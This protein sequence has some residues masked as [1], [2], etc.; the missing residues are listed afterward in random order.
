MS[1]PR[2]PRVRRLRGNLLATYGVYAVSLAS[3]LVVTPVVYH[4][5]GR[6][7]F[8]LWSFVLSASVLLTLLDLGVAPTIV[9]FS[10]AY[11]GAG[12]EER[13]SELASVGLVVYAVVGTLSILLG[14]VLAWIVPWLTDVPTG[15]VG[16]VRLATLL[17]VVGVGLRLP[18]GLFVSLLS[19]RQR[20]DVVN[21]SNAVAVALYAAAV[22]VVL[23]RG[24]G[25]VVVAALFLGMTLVRL[26]LPLLFVWRELPFLRLRP[27]LVTRARIREVLTVSGHNAVVH[28]A[29]KVVFSTDVI[30]VGIVLGPAA[31]ALYAIPAR[32]F[33]LL[34]GLGT[35]G[36]GL[37][38]AAYAELEGAAQA[39]RQRRLLLSGLRVGM[40]LALALGLPLVLIPDLLIRSWV[41]DGLEES[42][43]VGVLLGLAL[44]VRQPAHMLSQFLI[45]RGAQRPLARVVLAVVLVNLAGSILLAWAVGIWGVALST[46]ATEALAAVVLIP[47]LVQRTAGIPRRALAAAV[48]RPVPGALAV[49]AVVLVGAARLV[50]PDS[51]LVLA[52]VGALWVAGLAPVLWRLGLDR[53]EREELRRRMLARRAGGALVLD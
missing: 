5:L 34:F 17:L 33:E 35:A 18:L 3:G 1:D 40:G 32:L 39:E 20:Y 22:V 21:W 11:R 51:L 15:L 47:T 45:A 38:Y 16:E 10:A 8:G 24:G 9:R 30:V 44:I 28:L 13:T 19:G 52:P 7:E 41:G 43:A 25:I 50:E 6:E 36:P 48:V 29:A 49:A 14:L 12:E 23:E 27:S 2:A 53:R 31:A 4:A 46:L 42:T 26:S 37:L